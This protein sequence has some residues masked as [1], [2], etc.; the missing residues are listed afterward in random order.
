MYMREAYILQLE[1]LEIRE[2]EIERER[3]RE[4]MKNLN[5]KI[6]FNCRSSVQRQTC[7]SRS[8][9]SSTFGIDMGINPET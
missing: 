2:R 8:C 1:P 6:I 5:L 9:S 4:R 7:G 3:W